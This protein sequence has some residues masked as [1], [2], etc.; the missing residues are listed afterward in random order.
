LAEQGL[1]KPEPKVSPELP[2]QTIQIIF[3][4]LGSLNDL[5]MYDILSSEWTWLSGNTTANVNGVYGVQR[6]SSRSVYPGS[7]YDHQ[8]SFDASRNCLYVFGGWG[9]PQSG[10]TEGLFQ[11]SPADTHLMVVIVVLNDLWRFNLSS[12]EW[13]WLSGSSVG[14]VLGRYGTQGVSSPTNYPGAR[15]D[16]TLVV[17]SSS[18]RLY[19]FGG[20]GRAQ[21]TT[22]V[23]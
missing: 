6:N 8:I 11:S 9:Y 20:H 15:R 3:T 7:R 5:W 16:H 23:S 4:F 17:D 1:L 18:N 12:S 22:G 2:S 13:T 19:L 10:S 21:S 14:G